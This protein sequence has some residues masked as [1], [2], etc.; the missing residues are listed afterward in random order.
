MS[1]PG[2]L[3]Q[4]Q[5]SLISLSLWNGG[6][7]G[8]KQESK[9]SRKRG[10]IRICTGNPSALS[11]CFSRTR[12]AAEEERTFCYE[13][14]VDG[15]DTVTVQKGDIIT[16]TCTL[17]RTD[18]AQEYLMYAM[19]DEISYD[20]SC[21]RLIEDSVMTK[22]EIQTTDIA[23]QDDMRRFY[24]NYVSMEGG[25]LWKEKVLLGNFQMEVTG[26]KGETQITSEDFLVSKE[27]GT[28][29]FFCKAKD[30]TV[31]I[32]SEDQASS[33]TDE[34]DET[35]G[36]QESEGTDG[37]ET[38]K[39]EN[40]GFHWYWLLIILLLLLLLYGIRRKIRNTRSKGL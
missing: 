25:S 12:A 39:P 19:Q 1:P 11:G 4:Q 10:K 17:E 2:K 38:E 32:V 23:I 21:L 30:L 31:I 8:Q 35:D 36:T 28:D 29:S 14:T 40:T 22:N 37:E 33:G 13:L 16:V 7:I 34:T 20:S 3:L 15:K 6:H 9:I 18:A 26:E 27:D 24:V 5:H